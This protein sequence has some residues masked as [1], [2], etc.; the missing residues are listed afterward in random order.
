MRCIKSSYLTCKFDWLVFGHIHH[1]SVKMQA[2]PQM[3][4]PGDEIGQEID[5]LFEDREWYAETDDMV[6]H[7]MTKIF[8]ARK[9]IKYVGYY[10][11]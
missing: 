9:T 10:Q 4:Y 2:R 7:S 6:L 8:Y 3:P 11:L 5:V 1:P